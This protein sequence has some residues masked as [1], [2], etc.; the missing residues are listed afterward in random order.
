[1]PAA[2]RI[3]RQI[4]GDKVI[5]D[6]KQWRAAKRGLN[7]NFSWSPSGGS[8]CVTAQPSKNALREFFDNR[9]HGNGIWKWDHYFDIYDRHFHRFRGKEVHV[10][11]IGIYSG[12]SLE[13][14]RDYF[15]PQSCIYGVDIQPEC[16]AYESA[17]VKIF[18]GDQANSS[19]W[20]DVRRSVPTLDI[21]IDDGG[22]LPEQ[23]IVSIEELL[24]FMRPGGV[25]CCEDVHGVGHQFASYINGFAHKLNEWHIDP[26]DK[27]GRLVS[28]C[29]PFQAA[30]NSIH[31]YPFMAVLEKN[32][33]AV[34]ELV[35]PR[36]GTQWQPFMR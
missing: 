34:S 23:Q 16:R 35:A 36:H 22:H 21:V 7:A 20:R 25:Y 10:L 3:A 13:M 31:L 18:I 5:S 11:E 12:G 28:R 15:G 2:K 9:R 14:W 19:F 8:A 30:I 1:M 4:V 33:V 32:G 24:P 29:P 17:N 27:E 26:N 6:Y